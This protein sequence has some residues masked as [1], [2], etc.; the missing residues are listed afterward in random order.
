M[1]G[2]AAGA[3]VTYLVDQDMSDDDPLTAP[4][5]S[6][7]RRGIVKSGGRGQNRGGTTRRERTYGEGRRSF[8]KFRCQGGLVAET[9]TLRGGARRLCQRGAVISIH[10]VPGHA[11]VTGNEIADQW[12]GDAATR[13]L[14]RRVRTPPSVTRT[15]QGSP[16]VSRAFLRATLRGRAVSSWRDSIIKGC[17]RRR[18]FRI[19]REGTVP[20]I[21]TA[22]GRAGKD[23]AARFFQLASGHAMI[24]PFLE[25]KFKWVS[26]GQCWWCDGGRQSR[27]HLFKECRAWKN[28]IKKLWKEVGEISS[29]DRGSGERGP[30]CQRKGKRRKKGFGFFAQEYMVRPGNCSVGRL[31]GDTRFTDAILSFLRDTQVGLIKKGVIVRGEE[32]GQQNR[33]EEDCIA[34]GWLYIEEY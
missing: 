6:I 19:P 4:R 9:W 31:M 32:A 27:E 8:V 25:E 21:P 20:R 7:I 34:W 16:C 28:E 24:A 10:W 18:P 14:A 13:E 1:E 30:G 23:L 26:S 12:A 2:V 3:V 33:K 29:A 11:G 17:S 22:L 5:V 15:S